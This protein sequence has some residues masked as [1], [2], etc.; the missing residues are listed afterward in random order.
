MTRAEIPSLFNSFDAAT[1]RET[2]VPVAI[3]AMSLPSIMRIALLGTNAGLWPCETDGTLKRPIRIK[4][5]P[6]V[7]AAQRTAP[8]VCASSAGNTIGSESRAR[9]QAISSI[10]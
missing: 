4:T 9:I 5:G 6:G 8:S 7:L 3:I 2:K 10:E 1:A